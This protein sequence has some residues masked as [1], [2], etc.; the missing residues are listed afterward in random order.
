MSRAEEVRAMR[1][2]G[3]SIDEIC[4]RLG[5]YE[6]NQRHEVTR[7][8]RKMGKPTTDEEKHV[9]IARGQLHDNDWADEYIREK[10]EGRFI[11]VSDYKGMDERIILK[12]TICGNEQDTSFAT[13]RSRRKTR[14]N[15]CYQIELEENQKKREQRKEEERHRRTVEKA[16]AMKAKAC[17]GKQIELSFCRSC[18]LALISNAT[19]CSTCAKRRDN[20][21][22]KLKRRIKIKK[23]L[24]DSDITLDGLIKR[25]GCRCYLCGEECDRED[26]IERDGAFIAGNRYPSID[27]II[28]LAKGGKH[29]WNNVKVAHRICNSLKSDKG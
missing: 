27:H 11:R 24:V 17:S 12:C 7:V 25:D 13:L 28:P 20:K 10:T 26:Y 9:S 22:H 21:N 3:M 14:C 5:A 8:C 1:T 6:R 29:S 18:G 15:Y 16:D 2:K 23:A 19:W 4:E